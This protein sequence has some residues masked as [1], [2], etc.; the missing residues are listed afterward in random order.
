M[1]YVGAR[2][3]RR[4]LR[5]TAAAKCQREHAR[6]VL[7]EH[8]LAL[9]G[10]GRRRAQLDRRRRPRRRRARVRAAAT[11]ELDR[12]L[13][14]RGPPSASTPSSARL[15][16]PSGDRVRPPP[17]AERRRAAR[18]GPA[19]TARRRPPATASPVSAERHRRRR[20][21]QPEA[22]RHRA[23][24]AAGLRRR[25]AKSRV[26]PAC[27]SDGVVGR[28][29]SS[30]SSLTVSMPLSVV[31]GVAAERERVREAERQLLARPGADLDR[32]PRLELLL[33]RVRLRRCSTRVGEP[34][35]E[36]RRV[37]RARRAG[38]VIRMPIGSPAS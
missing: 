31:V 18:T 5:V 8:H 19:S 11:V 20:L 36:H 38:S 23:P 32:G 6:L 9:A 15:A 28:L 29:A 16:Q 37:E 26:T 27:S 17:L 34:E 22:A 13:R 2:R 1:R 7:G 24:V 4:A 35:V 14:R 12:R 30:T 3:R 10:R 21:A 25:R 33:A